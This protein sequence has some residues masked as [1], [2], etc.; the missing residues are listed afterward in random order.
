MVCKTHSV[1]LVIVT[2]PEEKGKPTC[3]VE[4]LSLRANRLSL[5]KLEPTLESASDQTV[6][7][8]VV[9]YPICKGEGVAA[10]QALHKK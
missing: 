10:L 7:Q 9:S 3:L 6:E 2:P 8:A 4:L 5:G 1:L